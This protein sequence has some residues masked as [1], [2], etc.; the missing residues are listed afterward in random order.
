[1]KQEIRC[2]I[3]GGR[4]EGEKGGSFVCRDCGVAYSADR[5]R[6]LAAATREASV[7]AAS[8]EA[9]PQTPGER[10]AAA[11]EAE[12]AEEA[13]SAEAAGT[14]ADDSGENALLSEKEARLLVLERE[15]Q[16][17]LAEIR[18]A[19]GVFGPSR[20][21]ELSRR[22]RQVEREMARLQGRKWPWFF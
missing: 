9:A 12:A 10:T 15:Q 7:K 18:L 1:M 17:L 6:E 2:Q 21:R 8:A 22:L 3:C 13:A 16:R 11:D 14:A 4:L 20:R 19:D 5:L